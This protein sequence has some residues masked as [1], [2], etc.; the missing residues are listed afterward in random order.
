[1]MRQWWDEDVVAVMMRQWWDEDVVAVMM[2][3]WWDEDQVHMLSL[4]AL[5]VRCIGSSGAARHGTTCTAAA[6]A[7]S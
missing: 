7:C 6:A 2:R 5:K 3:Q 4:S 1:M